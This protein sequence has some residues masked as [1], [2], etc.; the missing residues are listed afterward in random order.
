MSSEEK[1]TTAE[2]VL[3]AGITTLATSVVAGLLGWIASSV[4]GIPIIGFWLIFIITFVI[5]GAYLWTAIRSGF[6]IE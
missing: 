5:V 6:T 4:F 1:V 2:V 3:T